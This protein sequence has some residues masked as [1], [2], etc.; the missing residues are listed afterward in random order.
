MGTELEVSVRRLAGCT[1]IRLTGEVDITTSGR[2]EKSFAEARNPG[3]PVVVD[4]SG[5]S[6]LD[7]TGLS[8]LLQA[9]AV[10]EQEGE[11]LHLAGLQPTPSRVIGLTGV[12][13]LFHLHDTLEEALA[14]AAG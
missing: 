14:A 7:S 11:P 3:T 2:L 10:G 6:F 4:L 13:R 1:L 9:H 12:D 8:V 5:M